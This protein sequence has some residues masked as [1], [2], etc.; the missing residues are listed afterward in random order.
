[1]YWPSDI[2][3][4]NLF[5]KIIMTRK[6]VYAFY[7]DLK[8]TGKFEDFRNRHPREMTKKRIGIILL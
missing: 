5:K 2:W 7:E 4:R 6:E 3:D 1:M 8:K